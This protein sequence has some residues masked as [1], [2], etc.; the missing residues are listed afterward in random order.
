MKKIF[1]FILSGVICIII[2]FT[3]IYFCYDV[4]QTN[5]KKTNIIE[6]I[7]SEQT[8]SLTLDC[9]SKDGVDFKVEITH[10]NDMN[11]KYEV[12]NEFRK[13]LNSVLYE[14]LQIDMIDVF[15]TLESKFSDDYHKIVTIT[16]HPSKC[17]NVKIKSITDEYIN[18]NI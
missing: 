18:V 9:I 4:I 8:V 10:Y 1:D 16:I 15:D 13:L 2:A 14:N 3:L 11:N 17:K 7:K 6:H 12:Y 5:N